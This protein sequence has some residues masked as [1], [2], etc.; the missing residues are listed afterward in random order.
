[1]S[2]WE[3]IEATM[4]ANAPEYPSSGD[5]TTVFGFKGS[6]ALGAFRSIDAAMEAGATTYHSV[7]DKDS[8][9][10]ARKAYT[11]YQQTMVFE[12][13]K[14][15]FDDYPMLNK[16]ASEIIYDAAYREGHSEGMHRV[17]DIF[18]ELATMAI[19]VH[20]ALSNA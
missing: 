12:L 19:E 8:Y 20:K 4:G 14:R 5:F 13:K 11:D 2:H 6:A 9:D 3:D 10:A 16:A 7:K 18:D 1:M 17:E 15:L